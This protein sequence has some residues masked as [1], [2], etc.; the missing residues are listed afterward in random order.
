[1]TL[2]GKGMA[3]AAIVTMKP[4]D[5]NMTEGAILAKVPFVC[6]PDR[7]LLSEIKT[8]QIVKVEADAGTVELIE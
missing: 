7:D 1:M 8:G 6:E 3:P 4:A 2:A 5:Y